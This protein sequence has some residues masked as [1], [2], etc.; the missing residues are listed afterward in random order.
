MNWKKPQNKIFFV[1]IAAADQKLFDITDWKRN[2]EAPRHQITL[3]DIETKQEY[4][5]E[6][7]DYLG[8]WKIDFLPDWIARLVTDKETITGPIFANLLRKRRPEF[9][10]AEKVLFYQLNQI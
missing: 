7:L 5:A 3:T 8:P 4:T 1:P 6:I 2:P 9:K 10:T